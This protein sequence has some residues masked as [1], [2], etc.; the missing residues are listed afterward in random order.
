MMA[1]PL[2]ESIPICH[3]FLS[4]AV[5]FVDLKQCHTFGSIVDFGS[6]I[7]QRSNIQCVFFICNKQKNITGQ[8]LQKVSKKTTKVL[9][10]CYKN[11]PIKM[12]RNREVITLEFI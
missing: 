1:R 4:Y 3:T 11:V 8:I 10:F 6:K 9:L 2:G 5:Y 7:E 12:F